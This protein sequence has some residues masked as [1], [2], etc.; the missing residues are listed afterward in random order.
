MAGESKLERKVTRE[1]KK[2]GIVP[3]KLEAPPIGIPDHVYFA[4]HGTT[5][6]IEFKNPNGKGRISPEQFHQAE[7]LIDLGHMV[8]CI[9][10][11]NEA[12]LI[13]KYWSE[14]IPTIAAKNNAPLKHRI[15]T[16]ENFK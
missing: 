5:V 8:Y 1:V 14:Y 7:K 11:Y 12:L 10:N 6:F 16:R 3:V 15:L 9:D 13:L 2:H 4:P